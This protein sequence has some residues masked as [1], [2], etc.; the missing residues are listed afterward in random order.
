MPGTSDS[1]HAAREKLLDAEANLREHVERVAEMRRALPPG[2][3]VTDYE[4]FDGAKRV[5]LSELF[6]DGKPYLVM[7]HFMYWQ[8]DQEFCPM[9]SMWV[10]GWD[11]I[12]HHVAQRA[13]IVAA[14]LAPV[15]V[16]SAWANKRGWHRIR[17]LADAGPAFARDTGAEDA[18]GNPQPTVLVFEKTPE[19]IRHVYTAHAEFRDGYRGIDQLCPTWHIFDLLPTGRA[20]WIAGNDYP[21]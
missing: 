15:D 20:D 16:T 14:T 1:Y 6:A 4:F 3:N 17:V 11:G 10:D 9:C 2:P 8:D 7:Y 19:G 13:S 18:E 21:A 5:K 12:A